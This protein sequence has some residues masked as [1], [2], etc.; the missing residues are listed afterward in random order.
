MLGG[1]TTAEVSDMTRQAQVLLTETAIVVVEK[2]VAL[3]SIPI[4]VW[5]PSNP[6]GF[7]STWSS[8]S[9]NPEDLHALVG[10]LRIALGRP[11]EESIMGRV[12]SVMV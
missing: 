4:R 11:S 9:R 1:S 8:R 5:E 10:R 7:V 3:T 2:G 12:M 6:E